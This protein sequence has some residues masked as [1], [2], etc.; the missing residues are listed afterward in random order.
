MEPPFPYP[1]TRIA[2][3]EPKSD[4]GVL[5]HSGTT[6]L[7]HAYEI[8]KSGTVSMSLSPCKVARYVPPPGMMTLV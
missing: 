6:E 5:I 7:D 4:G 1:P 2:P 3:A 8:V